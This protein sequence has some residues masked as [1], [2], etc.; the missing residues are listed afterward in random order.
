MNTLCIIPARSGSKGIKNKNIKKINGKTLIEHAYNV[1]N[2][3]RIF[4]KIIL[5]TDSR[6]YLNL[7]KKKIDTPFLRP[8]K[9]SKDKTVDIE[10]LFYELKIYEKYYEKKFDYVCLLQPTSPLRTIN[11]LKKSFR[12]I[13]NLNADALWTVSKVDTRYHPIKQV[14]S[15]NF[16]LKYYDKRGKFYKLRNDLSKTFIR[17]GV[18]YFFSRKAIIQDKTIMPKK[19]CFYEVLNKVANIDDLKDLSFAIKNFKQ[20]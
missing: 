14:F 11:H 9:I 5:S 16:F 20:E 4:D 18:A 15:K 19:T 2:K 7:L 8:K 17:N 13:V 6:R 1:A 12:K 3:S 10:V